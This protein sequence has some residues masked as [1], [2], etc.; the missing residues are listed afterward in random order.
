M[1]AFVKSD[2][3]QLARDAQRRAEVEQ[4]DADLANVAANEVNI[5]ATS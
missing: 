1:I 4:V 2:W 5:E 3:P